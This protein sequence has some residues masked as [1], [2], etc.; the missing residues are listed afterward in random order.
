[1]RLVFP[2]WFRLRARGAENIPAEGGA[3][4]II[5]HL[6]FLDPAIV[7][8]PLGRPISYLARDS[9]FG[10]PGI[11][12]IL[13]HTETIPISREAASTSTIRLAI[14]RLREGFLVG[15]FPEGTRGSDEGIGE[16]KP[17]FLALLRRCDVPVIPV[18]IA[19]TGRALPRGAWFVRPRT[20]RVVYGRPIPS[21]RV[22]ELAGRGADEELLREIRSQLEKVSRD[23]KAWIEG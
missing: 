1:M 13:R 9:L 5:N 8:V 16:L 18:G 7:G 11:G 2:A 22:K 4:L 20:C 6:S 21:A 15:I 14:Q 12:W 17:G 10:V 23:A 19:G 3:L